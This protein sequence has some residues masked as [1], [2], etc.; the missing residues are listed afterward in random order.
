MTTENSSQE[1]AP[2]SAPTSTEGSQQT[3]SSTPAPEAQAT[4]TPTSGSAGEAALA[5]TTQTAPLNA[6][7]TPAAVVP[8]QFKPN[9]KF[10]AFEKEYEVEDLYKGLI[11][12]AETEDKVKKL[13][14]KAYAMETMKERLEGT[15]QELQTFRGQVEPKLRAYDFFDHLLQNKDFDTL[16][17][18]LQVPDQELFDFVE[19]KLALHKATPEQRA[20]YQQQI[21]MRANS[22]LKDQQLSQLQQEHMTAQA[23]AKTMVLDQLVSRPDVAKYASAWDE[24]SG[25][26]GAFRQLVIDEALAHFHRTQ[27]D[28]SPD[29][30]VNL[31]V[32]KFGKIIPY[33]VAGAQAQP[34]AQV[35]GGSPQAGHHTPPP[36]IPNIAGRG[37]SPIKKVPRS[38]DDLKKIA[39]EMN[40]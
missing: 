8:P 31:V 12:D 11:K 15:R 6:D 10:K 2:T 1:V 25:Q 32:Q 30:A 7:G 18:K 16:F 40:G 33:Q 5:A 19:R 39:K 38:L 24:K 23:E 21:D 14:S 4:T 17:A 35:T 22:Y 20:A 27:Q 9:F 36:V 34:G 26:V 13:H 3:P 37:T 28:L 29:Q